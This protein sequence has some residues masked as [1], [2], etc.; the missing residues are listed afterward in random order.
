[1]STDL[2]RSLDIKIAK[3]ELYEMQL[4]ETADEIEK[5]NIQNRK[6]AAESNSLAEQIEFC[7]CI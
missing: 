3:L 1:M 7:R 6:L 5:L 4:G 2:D